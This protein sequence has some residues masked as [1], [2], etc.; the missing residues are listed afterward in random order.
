M[1][2]EFFYPFPTI[3]TKRLILRKMKH[4]DAHDLYD[5]F[6]DPAVSEYSEWPPHKSYAY[7]RDYVRYVVKGYRF[8]E[9]RT[10]CI[11]LKSEN[12]VIGTCSFPSIDR[13]YKIAEIGYTIAR[14]YW[15]MGYGSEA[16]A[17][18][19]RFGFETVG[20][21]R[22]NARVAGDNLYSSAI[23]KKLGFKLEGRQTEGVICQNRIKT[24]LYYGITSRD[25]NKNK[26]L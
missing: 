16:V 22:I 3:E 14:P 17:A 24:L 12:K 26:N 13:N 18:L 10:F 20:L 25:Y 9:V 19:V 11:V 15:N 2:D 6:R 4:S 7:T 1:Y 5:C 8:D 21:I 23:L